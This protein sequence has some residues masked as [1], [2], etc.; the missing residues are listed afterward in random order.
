MAKIILTAIILLAVLAGVVILLD[1]VKVQTAPSPSASVSTTPTETPEVITGNIHVFS[2][3]PDDEVGLPLVIKGEARTFEAAFAY[4]VKNSKGNVLVEG[5]SMTTGTEDYPAFRP[6]EVTVNYPDPK[7]ASGSVEVFEYSAK[8]G[9]EINK[10][11]VPVRFKQDVAASIVKLYFAK[12]NELECRNVYPVEHRIA[13]TE[14]PLRT[15]LEE[16]F[17][18]PSSA[19]EKLGFRSAIP[20]F[21]FLGVTLSAGISK[22][23]FETP[24]KTEAEAHIGLCADQALTASITS[25]LKQFTSVKTV[26]IIVNGTLFEPEP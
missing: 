11:V 24:N 6:F 7:T 12:Q 14:T 8:D 23:S 5:H 19:E 17:R 9:S 1:N 2:P 26:Q 13:K 3:Q 20:P 10:V 4:R 16:L 18:G 22:V 21:K 25:T 15:T